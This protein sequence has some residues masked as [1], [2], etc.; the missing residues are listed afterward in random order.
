MFLN[1]L[2]CFVNKNDNIDNIDKNDNIYKKNLKILKRE[3]SIVLSSEYY[4]LKYWFNELLKYIIKEY[5]HYKNK[6]ELL[7]TSW[8]YI[9]IIKVSEYYKKY[10]KNYSGEYSKKNMLE[11]YITIKDTDFENEILSVID[12]HNFN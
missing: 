11:F 1:C 3:S 12:I 10:K 8:K 7:E 6:E 5:E 2:F 4:E 9:D